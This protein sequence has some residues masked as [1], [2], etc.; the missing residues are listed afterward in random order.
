MMDQ[1]DA[2]SARTGARVFRECGVEQ[3][4]VA[5]VQACGGDDIVQLRGAGVQ[6]VERVLVAAVVQQVLDLREKRERTSTKRYR[7]GV[8]RYS[9][10][11]EARQ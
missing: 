4:P 6:Q 10:S 9:M 7:G 1:S 2:G 11:S 3:V 8:Q 5:V